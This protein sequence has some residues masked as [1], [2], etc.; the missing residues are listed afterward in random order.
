VKYKLKDIQSF[1]CLQSITLSLGFFKSRLVLR[2]I[3]AQ[4]IF[5]GK[6]ILQISMKV[7][8]SEAGKGQKPEV[9]HSAGSCLGAW[10]SIPW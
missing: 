2:Q 8:G 9:V 6:M 4:V 5:L 10:G 3:N 1:S 7:R